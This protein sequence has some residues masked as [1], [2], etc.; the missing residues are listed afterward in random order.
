MSALLPTAVFSAGLTAPVQVA[1]ATTADPT[2]IVVTARRTEEV[3]QTVPIS[4]T[5]F[6]QD[7]LTERNVT[8]AGDLAAFTP[9]LAV[10]NRFGPDQATFAIRGFTQELRTTASVAV[11]FAD[12]VAPRGGG[13]VTAG[14]GAGPGSFFD[15]QN[16]QV[17]KGP[18]G[19]LFGR[20]TTGGAIQLVPQEPTSKLEGYLELSRGNYAMSRT[21]GVLN[22]PI[23]D[24]VRARFG[25]DTMKRDGYLVNTT[26]VGPSRFADVDYLAGRGS[27][28]VD[29]TDSIQNYTIFSQTNSENNGSIQA[30]FAC[31]SAALGSFC[32]EQL[33]QSHGFYNVADGDQPNPTSKLNQWQLINTTTW[34]ASD[35]FTLKNNLSYADLRQTT[36][37]PIFGTNFQIPVPAGLPSTLTYATSGTYGGMPTNWQSSMVEELQASGIAFDEKLTWQAGYYYEMSRPDGWAGSQ[38]VGQMACS[39]GTLS[40]DP[41]NWSCLNPGYSAPGDTPQTAGGNVTRT[42]YKT[43]YNNQALYSQGTYDISD[44]WR[45]TLGLRYTVDHT[46]S[47]S[48]STVWYGG[49]ATEDIVGASIPGVTFPINVACI[50]SGLPAN[51]S[52][53]HDHVSTKSEA[54]T[55]LFDVDYMPTA[56]IMAYAKYARGYRQGSVV[57]AAPVVLETYQPE[58]VDAYELGLKTSFRGPVPGTFNVALFYNELKDQQLQLGLFA[59]DPAKGSATTAIVNAGSSTIQGLEVESTLKLLT[60]LTFNLGYTYLDTHLDSANY[61]ALSPT[62][63]IEAPAAIKGDHLTFSP[64]HTVVTGLSYRLPLPVEVGDVS[65]G[66]NYTFT[67]AQSACSTVGTGSPFC[68]LGARQ[69]LSLNLGWKDIFGSPFD[70]SFFMTN[71]LNEKYYNYVSGTY[72]GTGFELGTQGEPKMWGARVKYNFR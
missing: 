49:L 66:A 30:M 64:R 20:N 17:L 13:N 60:D 24:S 55:W 61:P 51:G 43:E 32:A 11:Y 67:S 29:V 5:V 40:T 25:F 54:P 63:W 70:A 9:S 56:D 62:D 36:R 46:E 50:H 58:K 34:N 10:N 33:A 57:P 1:H 26:D 23:S 65:A 15:L 22:V 59:L 16:V 4:M 6:N 28:M 71:A 35:A 39:S 52:A 31:G 37:G 12:V 69:L 38:S 44:E 53:C 27:L 18:Q 7:M 47:N 21:Q 42:L 48:K 3:I 41:A 19:T 45:A 68:E 8:N 72:A 2:E 14:D